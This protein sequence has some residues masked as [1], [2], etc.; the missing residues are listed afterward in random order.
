KTT[1]AQ[2]KDAEERRQT[3]RRGP[4]DGL[5]NEPEGLPYQDERVEEGE[6]VPGFEPP[7]PAALSSARAVAPAPPSCPG[8]PSSR[9]IA[10]TVI[11]A[12]E[13]LSS[14]TARIVRIGMP[15]FETA[16]VETTRTS[17]SVGLPQ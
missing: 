15:G 2:T 11:P 4:G 16:N 3:D 1:G 14:P 7:L 13:M 17:A 10:N 6:E 12:G 5:G 9:V 8:P